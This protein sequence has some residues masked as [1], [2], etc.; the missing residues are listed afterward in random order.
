MRGRLVAPVTIVTSGEGTER[1]GLTVSSLFVV[2]GDP[3]LVHMVVGPTSDLWEAIAESARFVV[4]VCRAQD[5]HLA[6]VFAGLRPSPG[7]VFASV[8]TTASE[9]GPV[10]SELA[11]RLFCSLDSQTEVGY[12]GV[13]VGRID[14]VEATELADPLLHF[15]GG[16]RRLS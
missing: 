5:R 9:W 10:L 8:D 4:H 16:Y 11:N 1:A 6:D 12:S 3:A 15:R 7:G 14:R 2:E 13:V